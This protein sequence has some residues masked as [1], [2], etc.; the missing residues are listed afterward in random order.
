MRSGALAAVAASAALAGCPIPQPLPD[1]PAGTVT[2]P[3]IVMDQIAQRD[4]VVRVPTNCTS[5]APTYDLAATLIDV[6]TIE[7]VRARWFINYDP[8]DSSR[9]TPIQQVDIPGVDAN[10]PVTT[11][12]VPVFTFRPYD[13]FPTIGGTGGGSGRNVGAVHVVELVVSNGFDPD[14]SGPPA[15]LPNRTPLVGFETQGYRWMFLTVAESPGCSLGDPGCV[16]CPP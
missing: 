10:P 9:F 2:P 7:V 5:T 6:N 14:A 11:R 3:R 16:R 1:Y 4:T 8:S 13:G 15:V 12:S